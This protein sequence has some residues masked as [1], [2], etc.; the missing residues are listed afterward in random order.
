M[1]YCLLFTI[2]L[3][4]TFMMQATAC[5][6]SQSQI[7][8]VLMT[9]GYPAETSWKIFNASGAIV[10]QS[11]TPLSPNTLYTDS[12]CVP[13][14]QC[15]TFKI[16]DTYGDGICCTYGH[17][18]FK[19]FLDGV[20]KRYDSTFGSINVTMLG[21]PP[22]QDCSTAPTV[23]LGAHTAPGPNYWY[24][25]TP[26]T[27]GVY[28]ISDC[29]Q[30]NS[31]NTKLWMYDY[32]TNLVYDTSNIATIYY[33][34]NNCNTLN[35]TINASLIAGH[36]YYI[37]V[38]DV[39]SSCTGDSIHFSITQNPA[40]TGCLDTAACNFNP[41]ATIAGPCIYYPSVLCPT[42]P[43]L[44]ID[45]AYLTNSITTSIS[46]STD[47]CTIREGCLNGYNARELINFSTKIANI[48]ATDFSAG[49]PPL[50][51]NAYSPIYE[52]DPCHAHWHFKD[53][54][55]YLLIDS[56]NNI[57]PIGYKNGFCV[58]DL[59]CTT[60]TAKFGCNNM[61]ITSGCFD[62]YASGLPC[63]WVDVTGIPDGHYKLIVRAN[64]IPRPDFY[65]RYEVSYFNN[66][67]RVCINKYHD[68]QGMVQAQIIP[69][70]APYI[71]CMGV[72]NGLS[73]KDC[74]GTCNGTRLTGD[75]NQDSLRN[76]TDV[77]NYLIGAVNNTLPA[78][79]CNDLNADQKITV[80][81]AALLFDCFKHGPNGIPLGHSHRPCKFPDKITNPN[82][83]ASFSLGSIDYI[84]NII[85]VYILNPDSKILGYQLNIKG[86]HLIGAQNSITGYNPQIHFTPAGGVIVLTNDEVPIPKNQ[87]TTQLLRLAFDAID[88][89]HVCIQNIVAV[90]NEAYEEIMTAVVDSACVAAVPTVTPTAV[91]H[92]GMW[93]PAHN[94]YPNPF[95]NTAHLIVDDPARAFYTVTLFDVLGR[96]LR[97]YPAQNT[98]TLAIDKGS[99]SP[100][101]YY[102]QVQSSSGQFQE[103]LI[104]Q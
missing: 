65:G 89:N 84:N 77:T 63:Q 47:V 73:V 30:G 36:T 68:A 79:T 66:W 10:A 48:G 43:D 57:I 26:A 17:G 59:G 92:T 93:Q 87:V 21:C 98:A 91:G 53:Y 16:F 76:G 61:G 97:T 37:R 81:D 41:F 1:K 45:S 6:G 60:G 101:M 14:G 72:Q 27:T 90:D 80:T 103:K 18:Y 51:P 44:A 100:G 40:V 19:V 86:L 67:A 56:N 4:S 24:A 28:T 55:E 3:F 64:W 12:L 8:V 23:G 69:N 32:C 71:D 94:V 46:N 62:V 13:N 11:G 78:T 25:F 29:N 2:F 39:Q 42:G 50:N 38:G 49:T 104:I 88:S 9:D 74:A 85:N 95:S 7:K 31:C 20:L 70:C 34:N 83:H 35:E 102:L 15:Y 52:Y 75:L 5:T 58:L 33:A 96:A 22:G 54:A 99:L 82:Q